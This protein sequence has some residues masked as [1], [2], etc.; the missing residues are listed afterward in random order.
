[1]NIVY[2]IKWSI[3]F[4]LVLNSLI[5]IKNF[6]IYGSENIIQYYRGELGEYII[7]GV[8]SLISGWI[9]AERRLRLKNKNTKE[10]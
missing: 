7:L 8:L 1:M 4:C 3:Y 2:K 6:K 5:F 10:I 9:I